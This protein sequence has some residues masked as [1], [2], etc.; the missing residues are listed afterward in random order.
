MWHDAGVTPDDA[1]F[2]DVTELDRYRRGPLSE[3][4]RARRTLE[5]LVAQM[6]PLA[7]EADAGDAELRRS[8]L[9]VDHVF[10]RMFTCR[11]TRSAS[12]RNPRLLQQRLALRP[13]PHGHASLRPTFGP[14]R[15]CVT[16]ELRLKVS[17]PPARCGA[18]WR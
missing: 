6:S 16:P 1:A 17:A 14:A 11:A 8:P 7:R 15:R 9:G 3:R 5:I 2:V 12:W 18:K 4:N 10:F 13:L